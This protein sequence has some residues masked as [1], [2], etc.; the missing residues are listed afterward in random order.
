MYLYLKVRNEV[1]L[2]YEKSKEVISN[3]L[4]ITKTNILMTDHFTQWSDVLA[5]F[6]ATTP[7]A[8]RA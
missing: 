2:L 4:F 7:T 6:N 1:T 3:E 5:I 8:A